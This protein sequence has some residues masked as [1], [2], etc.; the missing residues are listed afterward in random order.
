M[1]GKPV[2]TPRRAGL[3]SFG[4]GGANAHVIVEESPEPAVA[5]S[6]PDRPVHLLALSAR[7]EKSLQQHVLG[8]RQYIERS[9][10]DLSHLCYSVNTGRKHSEHRIALPAAGRE[11]LVRALRELGD[12]AESRTSHR[13]LAASP[14]AL[15]AGF[16][17]TGQGSQYVGMGKQL[18]DTQPVFPRR[19]I[20]AR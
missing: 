20:G 5:T 8:L 3:S 12:D 18:Y 1:D 13:G 15:K 6:Q 9:Q 7:S 4:V 17:F 11:E 10:S 19:S 14:S 2:S 16:L